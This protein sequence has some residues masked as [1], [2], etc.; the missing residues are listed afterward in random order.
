MLFMQR[1]T[2]AM[3]CNTRFLALPAA[4][5]GLSLICPGCGNTDV[6]ETPSAGQTGQLKQQPSA[7]PPKSQKEYYERQQQANQATPKKGGAE[8]TKGTN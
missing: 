4:C 2:I 1:R 6:N 8:T 5:L 7:P 3:R